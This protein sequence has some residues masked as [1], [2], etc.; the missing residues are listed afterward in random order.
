MF[1][2]V[3]Q[4]GARI[5]SSDGVA[6]NEPLLGKEG[7]V[8]RGI[9][10][11]AGHYVAFG[12]FGGNN[13]FASSSDGK[14]WSSSQQDAKYSRYI[15]GIGFGAG[16]FVAVG[17]DPGSVGGAR[18]FS[19]ISPDGAAW[20]K[21][22]ET[23]AKFVLRRIAFGNDRFVGVGDRGRRSYSTDGGIAWEDVPKPKATDTLIDIAFGNGLFVGV[24]LHGSRM[25]T[26]DGITWS[27]RL[28]GEEG[29]HCNSVI[30]T[31]EKFVAVGQGGTYFSP[32]GEQWER[33]PNH[34]APIA[35]AYGDKKFVGLNWKGRILV[36]ADALQ[37]REVFKC[38]HHFEAIAFGS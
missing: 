9:C 23:E 18:G 7:E 5:S 4:Q 10:F 13:M 17:G 16:Q 3:G 28:V 1:I 27:E 32:D 22:H 30:W 11:G 29:E 33:V 38:E 24:G 37:W 20:S 26:R 31:G 21:L 19:V 6:W 25:S 2:A 36:S 34:D 15:R 8:Y 12:T 35:V 14:T